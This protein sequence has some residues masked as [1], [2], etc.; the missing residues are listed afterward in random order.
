MAGART[1]EHASR[2]NQLDISSCTNPPRGSS[3]A[4][5][6]QSHADLITAVATWRS[7]AFSITVARYEQQKTFRIL[8]PARRQSFCLAPA[9]DRRHDG[10]QPG[11]Q[12]HA[13]LPQAS[14]LPRPVFSQVPR[15]VEPRRYS[16][17]PTLFC[18]G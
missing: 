5:T 8:Y 7:T 17:I 6:S 9:D 1:V 11:T 2:T 12:H 3:V 18:Q 14:P 10:A 13:V 16:G 15:A 4:T